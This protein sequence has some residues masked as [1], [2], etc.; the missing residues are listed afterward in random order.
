MYLS[1]SHE[2][3]LEMGKLRRT[4]A[5]VDDDASIRRS[6]GRLLNAYGFAATEYASAEAF[7]AQYESIDVACLVLDIDLDGGM[8]GM[9]LQ[10]RLKEAGSNLPVIFMTALEERRLQAEAEWAGCIAYLRKPFAGSDLIAAINKAL[11]V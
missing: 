7:L 2:W 4:V 9:Q 6:V 11:G 5:V 8:S 10:R 3:G 1:H